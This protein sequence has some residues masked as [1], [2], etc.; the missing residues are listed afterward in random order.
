MV[1]SDLVCGFYFYLKSQSLDVLQQYRWVEIWYAYQCDVPSI[2]CSHD[3]VT[4]HLL[5]TSLTMEN[6]A[7]YWGSP[8]NRI[9]EQRDTSPSDS[10][11]EQGMPPMLISADASLIHNFHFTRCITLI[12]RFPK[13]LP[14]H[15]L[16]FLPLNTSCLRRYVS[17]LRFRRRLCADLVRWR[18]AKSCPKTWRWNMHRWIRMEIVWTLGESLEPLDNRIQS[19]IACLLSLCR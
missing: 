8:K 14:C 4:K 12:E 2:K 5:V 3:M 13:F 9:R 1:G 10:Y 16:V 17:T 19:Q 18:T 7:S 6:E 15:P 11:R